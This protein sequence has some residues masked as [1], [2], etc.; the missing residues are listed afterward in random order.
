MGNNKI[1][2]KLAICN[3]YVHISL[4]TFMY[5]GKCLYGDALKQKLLEIR[6]L[7]ERVVYILMDRIN[8]PTQESVIVGCDSK[9]PFH[10]TSTEIGVYGVLVRYGDSAIAT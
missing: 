5:V 7:E 9:Y 6:G 8:H 1:I 10:Q 3:S 2:T 4:F